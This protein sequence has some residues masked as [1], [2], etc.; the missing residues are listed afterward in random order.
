M[1]ESANHPRAVDRAASWLTLILMVALGLRMLAAVAV[2]WYAQGQGKLCVFADTAIYWELAR[3]I[4]AGDPYV[5]SQWGVPHYALRTPGYPLFLAACREAFGANLLAVRLVQAALGVV[6]VWLVA[7][8]TGAVVGDVMGPGGAMAPSPGERLAPSPL[9]GE[10]WGEGAAGVDP[11]RPGLEQGP[12][13]PSES[14]GGATAPSPQ[15]SPA[16]GEGARKRPDSL[17][18]S[19]GRCEP[20]GPRPWPGIPLVA[21]ALAAVHPYVVGMSALVLSEATF[22]PLMLA[23]LWGLASLW[24]TPGPRRPW[25]VAVGT[26]LAMG[27]AILSRPSWALFVPA[28]LA[29]WVVGAGR[30]SR[31]K[32]ARNAIVV[33]LATASVMAPWWVRNG[34]VFGRFVPTALW[35]GA[36]LY[37]GIGPQ[38]T[39]TSDMRFVDEPDVRGLGESEQD[40]AFRARSVAFARSHPGRVVG[41]A[42]IKLGRFWSPW[43]NADTLQAPGVAVASAAVTLP[44]FALIALGAFDRRRDFR[45]LVL[46][47]GPLAY[48]CVLHMV[49]VSS[50]R[51]RIPGEVPAL[52]LASV[53]LGRLP[54]RPRPR[55]PGGP[56][57]QGGTRQMGIRRRLRKVLGWGLFLALA[58]L[59]G[60]TIAA[61]HYATDSDTLSD[62]VRREAPKYLPG[63]RVNVL[64]TK[65]RPFRGDVTFDHLSVHEPG[66]GLPGREVAHSPWIKI[67]FDPWAMIKGRF[68]PVDVTVARPTIRLHRKADGSWNV[69][70]LLAD[71]WPVPAGGPI[72]PIAIQDGVIELFEDGAKDPLVLVHGVSI[73]IPAS[74]GSPAPVAFELKAKGDAGLFEGVHVKGTIDLGTGRVSLNSGELDRLT[75]SESLRGHLPIRAREWLDR[76]GLAGGE[77]YAGLSSLTFDPGA[78][79]PLHYQVRANLRRGLWK[80]PKLPFPISDVSVDIEAKDGELTILRADGSDGRTGLSLKGKA[81]LNPDEPARSTFEVVAKATNL[82]LDSRLR[83]WIPDPQAREIWDAYFPGVAQTPSTSAGWISVE[84][85]VARAA[86]G[87][88]IDVAADVECLDV[89]MKYKHFAYPVD[90]IKGTIHYTPERMELKVRTSVGDKPVRVTGTVDDPG[91]DAVARLTFE[92][93]SLPVDAALFNALPP[94]VKPVV[95][96]FRP[97][98]TVQGKANLVRLPPLEKGDDPRGRVRFDAWID[99]NPGCSITWA[100]LKYPVM[101]L[102]GKLEIHPDLWIFREMKGSNG[103]ATITAAGQVEQLNRNKPKGA[104]DAMKVDLQVRA[105]NLPFDQQLRD[106]LP[107]PWKVTWTTLNPTGASDIDATIAVDPRKPPRDR[108]HYRIVVVPRKATNV[109]LR[110][111]PLVG[112]GA[113]PVGMIELPMDEVAGRFV[114]DTAKTPHTSMT[115]VRFSFQRAPVTFVQ[116]QVDVQDSGQFQLGV[117]Q[118]EVTGLRLDEDLRKYMPPVMAQFSRRL[119]EDKISK[120]KANLGLGWS[121]KPGESAWCRWNDARVILVDNQVS[122]GTDL[123]LEHIQGELYPVEGAFNGRDLSVQGKLNLDSIAVFGQQVTRLTADLKVEDGFARLEQVGG[124]VLGGTLDGHVRASLDASPRYSLRMEVKGA[125]L[126]DY[127]MNLPGHQGFR[128]LVSGRIELSGMGYDPHTI[129]GDGSARIV[130]GELGT[131]PAA[132]RFVNVLKL[133][134]DAKTAFDS[135]DVAFKIDNGETTL[136]PVRLV[137]NAF[138]LDGK[139]TLDVRGELDL[140]LR[141]LPGRDSLHVPLLSDLTRELSGQILVVRVHGP[142]GSP[143]FKPEAIP[144]PGELIKA[145]KRKSDIKRTGLIGPF[146]SGLEPRIRAGLAGRWFGQEE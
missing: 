57:V 14:P 61:Y 17:P 75:L 23:G 120:I 103:Q 118:L 4:V 59:V 95:A 137:G 36:S 5:V 30:G 65:L 76:A 26:G 8:L 69:R 73:N 146:K 35:V 38:A 21:A 90:H 60:G 72:P 28:V 48:F 18:D 133:A 117:S 46:L 49:F 108:E 82:E 12:R 29:A 1:A 45:A 104:P 13:A 50:I 129:T 58:I 83:N 47:A 106:A 115:D 39:G 113:P 44:I 122:M 112:A 63:C 68:E 42:W 114:Y 141:I 10:G 34:R 78:N 102:T 55:G 41:L 121:G 144:G 32:A 127:A 135:A 98:G 51:Y 79:P 9:A 62:L 40:A 110:F 77:V 27:A 119:K 96:S 70:G 86:P 123:G 143:T 22:L 140:K 24:R 97:T 25:L 136:D 54:G 109:K 84:A 145:Q 16:R 31:G 138:S 81:R 99:L 80:C 66:E 142:A 64:R 87:A 56:P 130:Q 85:T 94:E 126:R 37:D 107:T 71:P 128:G 124:K 6:G 101:N 43:P 19:G 11:A 7:R 67:R 111:K 88:K 20:P 132:V 74:A 93:E 131:L 116:G 92:V 134:K 3:A 125:D 33:A 100:G 15:P 52:G 2:T 105:R 91:P 53:G 139:G 89:S